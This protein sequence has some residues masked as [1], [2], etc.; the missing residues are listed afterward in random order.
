MNAHGHPDDCACGTCWEPRPAPGQTMADHLTEE[1]EKE[2][3]LMDQEHL[4]LMMGMVAREHQRR[5]PLEGMTTLSK[6]EGGRADT[7][8]TKALIKIFAD[9]FNA[10]MSDE[11]L[12]EVDFIDMFMAMVNFDRLVL[13]TIEEQSNLNTLEQKRGLRSLFITTVSESL[14]KRVTN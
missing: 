1:L 14:M 3:R 9:A 4:D 13:E 10:R 5:N 7:E 6:R 12:P 11:S 2:L 8:S